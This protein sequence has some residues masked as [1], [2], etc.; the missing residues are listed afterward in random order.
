[1][2]CE[3]TYT[4]DPIYMYICITNTHTHMILYTCAYI[5]NTH[6]HVFMTRCMYIRINAHTYVY[7]CIYMT[8][9][10]YTRIHDPKDTIK[11]KQKPQIHPKKT[12]QHS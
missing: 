11:S 8:K 12:R 2:Y 9:Y 6:T 3:Y 7:T 5:L 10:T 4:H 1:M